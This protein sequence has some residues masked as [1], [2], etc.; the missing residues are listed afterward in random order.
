MATNATCP[1]L[2]AAKKFGEKYPGVWKVIDKLITSV[3]NVEWNHDTC[4]CPIAAALSALT[5]YVSVR[6]ATGLASY[7]AALSTWRRT[8][9]VY[10]FDYS[11]VSE[12]IAT[13][14]DF[15]IPIDI[16]YHLPAQCVYIQYPAGSHPD[17]DGFFVHIE[18]DVKTDGKE[19]RIHYINH[20]GEYVFPFIVHLIPGGTVGDGIEETV[21][22][23]QGNSAFFG[24]AAI[25]A[26]EQFREMK[27]IVIEMMQLVLY[28]C[29]ENADV[30]ENES[31]AKIY[32]KPTK[33]E[34]KMREVRRWDVGVHV[35]KAL[36]AAEKRATTADSSPEH[37]NSE[38]K[39]KNRPHV[40]RSHWHHFWAGS[41]ENKK[42]IL[43]WVNT[44]LVNAKDGD[45]TTTIHDVKS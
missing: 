36:R 6:K 37:H 7:A 28:I 4:Y 42:L 33:I 17:I 39:F 22:V 18:H 15:T 38:R 34:D 26:G 3:E 12:L 1:P 41:G 43:R 2:A 19:L 14:E 21:R 35:S 13:A 45:I 29:A 27:Q 8:K 31:Q 23:T 5:L 20:R 11:I 32:R 40:R 44:T 9:L 16:L 24:T 25:A 30:S 10:R